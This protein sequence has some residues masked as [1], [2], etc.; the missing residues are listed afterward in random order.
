MNNFLHVNDLSSADLEAILDK[1]HW[2][3]NKF[4]DNEN[5]FSI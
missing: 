5:I 1:A 2:I 4:K 3:K